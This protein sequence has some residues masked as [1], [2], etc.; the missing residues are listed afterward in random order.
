[1]QT[2]RILQFFGWCAKALQRWMLTRQLWMPESKCTKIAHGANFKRSVRQKKPSQNEQLQEM[3]CPKINDFAASLTHELNT[4]SASWPFV[5]ELPGDTVSP[6]WCAVHICCA[7]HVGTHQPW[8]NIAVYVS[9]HQNHSTEAV[10]NRQESALHAMP[11][12]TH[13]HSNAKHKRTRTGKLDNHILPSLPEL[14]KWETI[15]RAC[16]LKPK[17]KK[18]CQTPLLQ[19]D[20]VHRI[21]TIEPFAIQRP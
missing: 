10:S 17:W 1:M 9:T 7:V 5:C 6:L 20:K 13:M 11:R 19:H 4:P 12:N 8:T 3:R 21:K 2:C 16:R 14:S 18:K 15:I